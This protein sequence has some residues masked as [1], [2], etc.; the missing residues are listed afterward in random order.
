ML[1][2]Y[3]ALLL[4]Q[5]IRLSCCPLKKEHNK[6]CITKKERTSLQISFEKTQYN[7]LGTEK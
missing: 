2:G 4:S 6:E 7:K 1:L 5:M 3:W